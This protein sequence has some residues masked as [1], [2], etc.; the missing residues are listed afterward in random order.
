M[1]Y[2]NKITGAELSE[3]EYED[4][5]KREAREA[6]ESYFNEIN[7]VLSVKTYEVFLLSMYESDTDFVLVDEEGKIIQE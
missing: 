4:L 7:D 5:I 3:K 1:K 6:Y 2:K